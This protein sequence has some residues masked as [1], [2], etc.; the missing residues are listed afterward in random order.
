MDMP[1]VPAL[2]TGIFFSSFVVGSG[3]GR[4]PVFIPFVEPCVAVGDEAAGAT[5]VCAAATGA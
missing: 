5:P 3:L 1:N 2:N 4:P